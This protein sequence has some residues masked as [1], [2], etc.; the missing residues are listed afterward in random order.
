VKDLVRAT[1]FGPNY[2]WWALWV[3]TLA[4]FMATSDAGLLSVSL[5]VITAEFHADVAVAGWIILI[6][7]L[8]TGSLYLP[9]GRLADLAG[10][11]KVFIAGFLLYSVNSGLA[12]FCQGPGQLIF[13]RSIQA[14]GSALMIGNTFA[15]IT[16]L[17]PPEER[18]RALGFSGGTSSA[19]GFTL[20][21]ILGGFITHAFGWRYIFY[22]TSF[23]GLLGFVSAIFVLREEAT[24]LPRRKKDEAFDFAGAALFAVGLTSFL[25]AMTPGQKG[26][27]RSHLVWMESLIALSS[28]ALFIWWESRARY[29]LLDLNLFRVRTFAFGNLARLSDFVG[30]GMNGLVMPFF[31]Q[32]A[33]GMDPLRAGLLMTPTPL[34]LALLSPVSGWLSEKISPSVLASIGLAIMGVSLMS[35]GFLRVGTGSVEVVTLLAFLGLGLGLYQTPNNNSLMSSIPEN[36]LGVAS[37]FL[38]MIRSVGQSI[39]TALAATIVSAALV[40]V[41]GQTSL[42]DLGLGVPAGRNPLLLAAFMQ[43]CWYTYFTAALVCFAG[44]AASLIADSGKARKKEA[45]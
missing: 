29:P 38:S 45:K 5:P 44:A 14:V 6:Y 4:T 39:G 3:P 8:V 13:F 30:T 26:L 35:I 21:P 32:L 7:T 2:R 22:V 28:L 37:S 25:L 10:R 33:L 17:F 24:P 41:A 19:L 43:G 27:W 9:G 40:A 11:K 18:G 36:R 15:M 42:K 20:G 23:L 1:I 34:M 12:G 16:V 31:L